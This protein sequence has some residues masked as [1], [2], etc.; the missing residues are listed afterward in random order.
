MILQNI[1]IYFLAPRVFGMHFDFFAASP[2]D[3]ERTVFFSLVLRTAECIFRPNN[4]QL[5][6]TSKNMHRFWEIRV[7]KDAWRALQN[8]IFFLHQQQKECSCCRGDVQ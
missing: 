4:A 7:Y 5:C 8:G 1:F 6:S 3:R 2:A